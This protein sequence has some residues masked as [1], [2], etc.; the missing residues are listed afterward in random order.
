M[1]QFNAFP[2]IP[3]FQPI[4]C[5]ASSSRATIYPRRIPT[6]P[7]PTNHNAPLGALDIPFPKRQVRRLAMPA[8]LGF[9]SG[10]MVL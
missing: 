6:Y 2:Q 10:M 9:A 8:E 1:S 5:P 3:D 4:L 7:F